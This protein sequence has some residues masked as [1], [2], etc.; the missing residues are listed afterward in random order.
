[1]N[2]MTQ[3]NSKDDGIDRYHDMDFEADKASQLK[4]IYADWAATY[5]QDNDDTLGTVSQPTT[6]EMFARHCADPNAKI[7]DVGCGTGLVGQHL[8]SAGY[9]NFDGTDPS[10]EMLEQAKARDYRNLFLLE[11]DQP[12]PV[13]DQSYDATLCV[14]VFTHGHLGS[15]GIDELIRVTK[16]NGLICFTVNEGVWESGEFEQAINTHT[17]QGRWKILEMQRRDYMVKEQV[18]AWYIAAQKT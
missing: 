17:Q 18:Q 9:R 16:H 7:I 15:E 2:A 4:Q 3:K 5:D 8:E 11:S 13:A 14:G 10:L 12:L 1:M 6:V